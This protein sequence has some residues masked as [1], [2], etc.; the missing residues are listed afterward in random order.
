MKI[1]HVCICSHVFCET[2]AYQDNLLPKYH[3]KLG[4]D[5]AIIAPVYSGFDKSTNQILQSPAGDSMMQNGIK[6]V[7]LKASLPC[8][9]NQHIHQ[10][11][12]LYKAL[13]NENPDLIFAH[14]IASLNYRCLVRYKAKHP[15]VKICFDNHADLVNSGHN[16][17][18]TLWT[19]FVMRNFVTKKISNISDYFYGVTPARCDYLNEM[20]GVPKEKIHLLPMG[21]DDEEMHY[22]QKESIRNEIRKEYGITDNDFLIV[23]G[24]KIDWLKNIH[25]LAKAVNDIPNERIKL[26][27]FGSIRDDLK[28]TFEQLK[29]DKVQYVGWVNSNEVYRYFYAADMVMF[30]GLHSVLWEQA[31]ASKVPCA[32][33]R[34]D[35][36]EHVDLGGNCIL[37]EGKNAE[38]YKTIIEKA[39]GNEEYYQRLKDNAES[40]KT[41][42]FLYSNI[43]QKVVD[44]VM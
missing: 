15:N 13:E 26:L 30:P 32:F 44:E 27:I 14:S 31:V 23:T 10:F 28:P 33:S 19:K 3:K 9:L 1:V 24:G 40:E 39:V 4:H 35:G 2:Y 7:R 37:M 6:L 25:T 20:L 12:G 29:S 17:F 16:A 38:Y 22:E 34:I 36:F 8:K 5:V 42:A 21:A 18:S 11:K 43:A 41:S